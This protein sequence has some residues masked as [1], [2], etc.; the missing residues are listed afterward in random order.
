MRL[1]ILTLAWYKT[2]LLILLATTITSAQVTASLALRQSRK[3]EL[4]PRAQARPLK[5]VLT[6]LEKTFHVYFTFESSVVKGLLV[7]QDVVP[8]PTQTIDEVLRQVLR[9]LSL[10][11]QKVSSDYYSIFENGKN[12]TPTPGDGQPVDVDSTGAAREGD[13]HAAVAT[14]A[15]NRSVASLRISGV[16]T[17]ETGTGMPGVNVLEKGT[18]NGATTDVN[19]N[20]ALEVSSGSAVLSISFVGYLPAEEAVGG[21]TE[22]NVQLTPDITTLLEVVVVGYGTARKADV[23]GAVATVKQEIFENR[24]LNN[25]YDAIQGTL[26]GVTITRASGQPGNQGY[27]MQVRGYSS[28]NGNAPLVLIDG[29]PGDL[30]VINPNDIAEITVLK[31]ASAAIYGSRAADGV[32]LVTTKKGKKGTPEVTYTA[33]YGIK[34][35]QYMRKMMNTLH[36]AE[37]LDEGL[38]NVGQAGFPDEVF[39]KIRANAAPEPTGW[40]Y[41]VTNYPGFYGNTDWN[42]VI[43]KNGTQQMHNVSISGG[44]DNTNYLM[45]VG[46]NRDNGVVNFF[47]NKSERYNIRLNYDFKL[48]KSLNVETRTSFENQ[49]TVEP[50]DLGNALENVPRLFPYQPVYNPSGQFYGYQGYQ[51]PAQILA[52]AGARKKNYSRLNTNVKLSY[53]I[54]EG[55]NL[56]GQ[57]AIKLDYYYENATSPTFTRYNWA[58]DVQDIRQ[59]PNSAFYTN[60]RSTNKLL[61]AYLDYAKQ[62]SDDHR[63]N[64]MVGASQEQNRYEKQ[65]NTGY[66]FSSNSIFTL[67]LADRSQ[68]AYANFS[69]ELN[70]WALI[71]YFGRF[72]Y[73]FR[74]KLNLSV[75]GRADGSSKFAPSKRWS[76]VFPAASLAYNL[77]EEDF[78]QSLELFDLIKIRASWGKTGNQEI[79]KL[80]L[81]DYIPL[82]TVDGKYPLGSPAA[83]LMGARAN[84]A[85]TDR[86]WE[87]IENKNIGID[88]ATLRSRLSFSFDYYIKTNDDM[89]VNIAVPAT[90]GGSA[91]SSNQ[92]KLETKGFELSASWRDKIGDFRYNVSAQLSDSKNK[93]VE[94]KNSDSF[95]EGLNNFR[96]GYS[97]YSY[98]GYV[99]DGIIKTQEQLDAYK[100]KFSSG[101]PTRIGLGDAMYKD[102]DGDG[103]LTAF[104]D[105]TKGLSGD[106]VYLGNLLPRYTYSFN[107]GMA[108]KQFDFQ[109]F[110]QG[111]GKRNIQYSGAIATPNNFFWPTLEYYYGR[112]WSPDRPDAEYPRDIP[113]SVGWGDVT[114]YNYHTSSLTMQNVSYLRAKTISVGY[115]LPSAILSRVKITSARVYVS[116]QDLFTISKGTLGGN[117]DPEDGYRNEGTYPFNRVYSIGLSIKF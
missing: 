14:P 1:S 43:Y 51:N 91:P 75:T 49:A 86:T 98:F 27:T 104:G 7:H 111:V 24:P 4:S 96:E 115:S 105:K 56:I 84:P 67:N 80:G 88:V 64:V 32:L 102:V 78:V 13:T 39:D 95:S 2:A 6:D 107:L 68:V 60:N 55:L 116:G 53:E 42:K 74:N 37:F 85:S 63:V 54:A 48:W 41:G 77:S 50:S 9:P 112:T 97:I 71:S 79:G 99:Y 92:G 103:K 44:S 58:G 5:D 109:A 25:S 17:D 100:E 57:A 36:F 34:K 52:E 66:N 83:G 108:Y 110:F 69:G 8:G 72:N 73:S 35:P 45:S 15:I 23:T 21:R 70:N 3:V 113:G 11:Y 65:S 20:Y 46:Y 47:D 10:S 114:G 12:A 101:I 29:I 81:Y 87:T 22:I 19:G 90:Y 93:L 28:M 61:Q 18:S 82:I 33:N 117:F 38:R 106:M 30:N 59:T 16:V 89:L 62:L 94:L 26:P 76:A 31:D 40:N